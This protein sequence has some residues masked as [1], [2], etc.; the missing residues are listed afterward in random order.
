GARIAVRLLVR[1]LVLAGDDV[2]GVE[3]RPVVFGS[4]RLVGSVVLLRFLQQLRK[5]RNVHRQILSSV[6]FGARNQRP[7][8]R[9]VISW[10][11]QVF[12]A[13]ALH[14]SHGRKRPRQG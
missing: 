4:G 11:T 12:P 3:A 5:G 14:L 7:G 8:R 6:G 10:S 13:G 1:A 9:S 2:G